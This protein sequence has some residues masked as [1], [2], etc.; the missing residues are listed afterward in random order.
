MAFSTI[1]KSSSYF[2]TKLWT[3]NGTNSTA[4]TGVGFQPDMTWIKNRSTTDNHAIF[5]AIRGAT[6]VKYY[7]VFVMIP[8][9]ELRRFYTS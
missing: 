4:I 8:G 3:G 9:F 1:S 7:E 2:N 5:D 6:N